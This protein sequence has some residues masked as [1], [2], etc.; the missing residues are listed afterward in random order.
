M[1]ALPEALQG[2]GNRLWHDRRYIL[3]SGII[4]ALG[5]AL[6]TL[7]FTIYYDFLQKPLPYPEAH[8]LV[9]IR[10]IVPAFGLDG[11]DAS[12]KLFSQLQQ[13]HHA[14][15]SQLAIASLDTPTTV[16]TIHGEAQV[17]HYK[18]VTPGFFA[19]LSGHP[20]LG[21]WPSAAAGHQDGPRETVISY[22]FWKSAFNQSPTAIGAEIPI[23]GQYFQVVGVLPKDFHMD[24]L[25]AEIYVPMVQPFPS[26]RAGNVNDI[27][28]ARLSPGTSP[29]DL[30]PWLNRMAQEAIQKMQPQFRTKA[31]QGFRITA[32]PLRDFLLYATQMRHLPWMYLGVGLFLWVIALL[33]VANYTLL[34][35]QSALRNYAIRQLLGASSG[36]LVRNL[37]AAQ[38]PML[39]LATVLAI[40]LYLLGM[41]WITSALFSSR[42]YAVFLGQGSL[43]T[44]LFLGALLLV[45]A[46]II[47]AFPLW[48]LRPA[49]LKA[50][51]AHDER[52]SSLSK[53]LQTLFQ[54]LGIVQVALAMGLLS[55][56]LSLALGGYFLAHRPLG[57]TSKN[58]YY[59]RVYLAPNMRPISSWQQIHDGLQ[60]SPWVKSSAFSLLLPLGGIGYAN[61]PMSNIR[62]GKILMNVV[63]RDYFPI[64]GIPLEEGQPM[65]A[66]SA[67]PSSAMWVDTNV[68]KKFFN[69][70]RCSGR[71]FKYPPLSVDG[72][73][74]KAVWKM[75]PDKNYLGIAYYPLNFKFGGFVTSGHL[76][77]TM[78]VHT[79]AAKESVLSTLRGALPGAMFTPLHAFQSLIT[80][81]RTGNL[82]FDMMLG[83]FAVLSAGISLFG[84]YTVQSYIQSGKMPEYRTRRILGAQDRDFYQQLGKGVFI[85][86]LPGMLIGGAVS[87]LLV[88][89][90]SDSFPYAMRFLWISL[91]MA[92]MAVTA[93]IA[94]SYY[95][96][97][98][99][100]L[101]ALSLTE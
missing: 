91:L 29:H 13:S 19:L 10:E 79:N 72:V 50:A 11:F 89:I 2:W 24:A 34:R 70:P 37:L 83:V 16:S 75:V 101:G 99:R 20:A 36:I 9:V 67:A 51:L 18:K 65:P 38:L 7:G 17:I 78:P 82:N 32:S 23:K 40:P 68:C 3:V 30:Q 60:G 4:L 71:I 88:H 56:T 69:T 84:V 55:T 45:S 77:L 35:H 26:K 47:V 100:L 15:I 93:A 1:S 58:V 57:L 92:F 49:T 73:V 41:H 44:G 95:M 33:N 86:V 54:G 59:D 61:T 96:T 46:G 8:R 31:Q 85:M 94:T 5:M 27:L 42:M 21:R 52:I 64:L 90:A 62:S 80:K 12:A 97:M 39:L 14:R 63:T 22:A 28:L 81:A 74:R 87:F 98:R 25:S 53:K 66:V 76:L 48:R 43:S 6:A